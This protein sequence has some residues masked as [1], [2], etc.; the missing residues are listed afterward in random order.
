MPDGE[1]SYREFDCALSVPYIGSM[2]ANQVHVGRMVRWLIA[3]SLLGLTGCCE[4]PDEILLD[5]LPIIIG[6]DEYNFTYG[7]EP[8]VTEI[9][10][11]LS[12]ERTFGCF[13]LT[14]DA[15]LEKQGNFLTL[16]L[17]SIGVQGGKCATL[18]G[19]AT[20][21]SSLDIQAGDY[22]LNIVSADDTDSYSLVISDSLIHLFP[23]EASFTTVNYPKVYRYPERSFAYTCGTLTENSWLCDAF[24]DSLETFLALEPHFFADTSAAWPYVRSSDGHYYDAPARY[25]RYLSAASFDSAG[26]LLQQF[27]ET[28]IMQYSLGTSLEL[29]NWKGE[30]FYSWL[31]N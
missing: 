26:V 5:T 4:E 16:R 23:I 2:S 18:V 11:Y 12:T 19:P 7:E 30:Y 31:F 25:Y 22:V 24:G 13:N 21:R 27:T 1:K 28:T 20:H 9:S 14:I 17:Y 29:N 15:S 3:G 8:S 6:V 10:V